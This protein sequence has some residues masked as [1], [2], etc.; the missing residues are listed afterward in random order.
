M[1]SSVPSP[2]NGSGKKLIDEPATSAQTKAD[3][4]E[5]RLLHLYRKAGKAGILAKPLRWAI[6]P[7]LSRASERTW[8]EFGRQSD[9][10]ENEESRM[11]AGEHVSLPAIWLV[12]V[13]TPT[14]LPGILHKMQR[15][16]EAAT[17]FRQHEDID[18]WLSSVRRRPWGAWINLN[19]VTREKVSFFAPDRRIDKIPDGVKYIR[20]GIVS[21][22]SSL[23]ALVAQF[24]L[25][26]E[27]S[28]L[29]NG[30]VNTD[31]TTFT[32]RDSNYVVSIHNVEQ[33][34]H[35]SVYKM[36]RELRED[37]EGWLRSRFPGFFAVRPK[38]AYPVVELLITDKALPWD[39]ALGRTG[40]RDRWA[41]IL[42]LFGAFG[43]WECE[44]LSALRMNEATRIGRRGSR[45][46]RQHVVVIAGRRK[47]LFEQER[48]KSAE[49]ESD[50][51][52]VQRIHDYAS[53]LAT[54]FAITAVLDEVESDL[55]SIRDLTDKALHGSSA[56][57]LDRLNARLLQLG[58]DGR[59]VASEIKDLVANER[60]WRFNVP[61]FRHV[62]HKGDRKDLLADVM[63]ETQEKQAD[64][65]IRT[66]N[67]L[68]ALLGTS[69]NLGVAARNMRLQGAVIWLTVVSVIA[70]VVAAWAAVIAIQR[71]DSAPR[72]PQSFSYSHNSI[73]APS[74]NHQERPRR[75]MRPASRQARVPSY[76]HV[77][78]GSHGERGQ[79]RVS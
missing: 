6:R 28:A 40:K 73:A 4:K 48:F 38:G 11:P 61:E 70:A 25:E 68:G 8:A 13:Y 30:I 45:E 10:A 3:S 17:G 34:K 55:S 14:T 12:E 63:R 21:I 69:A 62:N 27:L 35:D 23:T 41:D 46:R 78:P 58:L 52:A 16:M 15:Y 26:D 51:Y 5:Y 59:I 39:S 57:S 20:L 9:A 77:A 24:V 37:A 1:S 50:W 53:M 18:N 7:A 65:I 47:D 74:L 33:Q 42:D 22:T 56:R 66:E 31:R 54:R 72:S 71:P 29:L 64:R 43:Y 36:R 67:S 44:E 79:P 2:D 32:T 76:A 60:V 19:W 49:D 75:T